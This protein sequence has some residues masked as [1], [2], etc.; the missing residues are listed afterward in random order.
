MYNLHKEA[1]K[2][3]EVGKGWKDILAHTDIRAPDQGGNML[4][5][6]KPIPATQRMF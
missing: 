1:A 3:A 2:S 6:L 5:V 4:S